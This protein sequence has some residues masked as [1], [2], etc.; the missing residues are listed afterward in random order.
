MRF[1]LPLPKLPFGPVA[2]TPDGKTLLT[3][4]GHDKRTGEIVQ[5]AA[6]TGAELHRLKGHAFPLQCLCVSLD[7]QTLFSGS[8]EGGI[9]GEIQLWDLRTRQ[10]KLTLAGHRS[11]VTNLCVSPDGRT[12]V[13]SGIDRTLKLWS[14]GLGLRE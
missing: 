9:A 4:S 13:S 5:R 11:W 6:D 3:G 12:L 10:E 1:T 14:T 7:G 8:G 2:F